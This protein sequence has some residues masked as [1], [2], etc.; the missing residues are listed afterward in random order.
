MDGTKKRELVVVPPYAPS[1]NVDGLGGS[2]FL[3]VELLNIEGGGQGGNHKF[4]LFCPV[5]GPLFRVT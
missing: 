4:P 3:K 2:I 5:H 1:F